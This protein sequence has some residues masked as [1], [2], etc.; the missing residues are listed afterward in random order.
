MRRTMKSTLSFLGTALL[1]VGLASLFC[2]L[3]PVDPLHVLEGAL[4]AREEMVL[5]VVRLPR[6]FFGA[7]VGAALAV[8]GAALQ[9]LFGNP[10]ADPGLLGVSSG[11]SLGAVI[12]LFTGLPLL[13]SFFLP[14]GAFSGSLAAVGA[15]GLLARKS[16]EESTG[17]LLLGGVAISLLCG[18]LSTGL[19]SFAPP[20]VMQQYFFWTLGSLSGSSWRQA[21]LLLPMLGLMAALSLWGRQLNILS[22]GEEQALAVGM[23][24]RFW[25]GL[26]LVATALLTSLAVCLGGNIGFVGLIVPH[27]C[28]FAVGADHRRLLPCSA[29]AGALFLAFSDLLG[30]CIPFGEVRTGVMTAL[31]GAPY[32]LYLLY[33]R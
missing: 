21:I 24:V 10:L 12:V 4:T 9:G 2:G 6:F 13:S 30:R 11:A 8:S 16:L 18:A 5:L 25:R 3:I 15:V 22:L 1:L 31:I 7:F 19:L 17:T 32:F 33:H 27:M 20:S 28:R 14:L 29:L 23:D 26:I